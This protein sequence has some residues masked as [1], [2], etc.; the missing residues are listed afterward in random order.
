MNFRAAQTDDISWLVET[1]LTAYRTVFAPLLPACDWS[2]FDE[3]WFGQRF[4]CQW[5]DVMIAS[6]D[7]GRA[8]FCLMTHA[9]IDMLFVSERCRRVGTGRALLGQAVAQ[10]AKTLECFAVN[11][12]ARQFYERHGWIGRGGYARMFAGAT[13][14]FIGYRKT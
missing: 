3:D 10:G 11:W 8:G 2:T 1:A 5:A 14:E 7:D 13:C 4:A 6:H 9:N 12:R